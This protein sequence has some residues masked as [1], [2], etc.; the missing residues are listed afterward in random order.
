VS[1][2]AETA[3]RLRRAMSG[4][5]TERGASVAALANVRA[6]A[7]RETLIALLRDACA[8]DARVE[9]NSLLSHTHPLGFDKLV[10]IDAEPVFALRLHV[11]LP[12]AKPV[13]EHVHNHRF[14]FASAIVFGG[15]DMRTFMVSP[16]GSPMLE[17]REGIGT[18]RPDWKL[19][20]VG[21]AQLTTASL[22]RIGP[23]ACYA[24]S[25]E[26]LHQVAVEPQTFC[27]T[28]FLESAVLAPA[29]R[30]FGPVGAAEMAVRPKLPMAASDYRARLDVVL[31]ALTA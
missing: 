14:G 24:L 21:P 17:Y 22:C 2:L 10:L 3:G 30:V 26:T 16:S 5:R 8:D 12:S 7:E 9:S 15:Y 28:L 25:A 4:Q 23:G 13:V 19:N 20:P 6:L 11:W 29:T 18:V 27:V 1:T 31:A